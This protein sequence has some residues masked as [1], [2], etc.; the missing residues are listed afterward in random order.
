[1]I[2]ILAFLYSATL[3]TTLSGMEIV[4]AVAV[5]FWIFDSWKK[6]RLELP[7]WRPIVL[8]SGIVALG[9]LIGGATF[10][11]KLSDLFRLRFF[12]FFGAS[13]HL[14]KAVHFGKNRRWR[15]AWLVVFFI[16][17]VYSTLQH[18]IPLDLVRP[19]GHKVIL[20]ADGAGNGPLVL[21]LFNHH[22]TF[23]NVFLLYGPIFLSYGFC[24]FPRFIFAWGWAVWIYVLVLWTDSRIAW[25]AIPFTVVAVG[26]GKSWRWRGPVVMFLASLGLLLTLYTSNPHVRERF[27]KTFDLSHAQLSMTPRLKLW[28]AQWEFF[29]ESPLIGVGWN[30]NERRGHSMMESL[31]PGAINYSGHGHSLPLQMLAT[32]GIAGCVAFA[33]IWFGI[34]RMLGKCLM[35]A[36]ANCEERWIALGLSA[37]FIGF[38]I[39]GLTQWNFGDAEVLHNLMF[40]WGAASALV[41]ALVALVPGT[42]Q[43]RVNL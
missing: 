5:G 25:V 17:C 19:E 22:L 16:V 7:L 3:I 12:L 35:A 24:A 23:S 33:W 8:F 28:R 1:M 34:A 6:Q 36:H 31:Y 43:D 9:I 15:A 39:Q 41:P 21:G 29:K 14:F 40:L 27:G 2:G 37:S 30:N 38:W 20:F 13:A 32:T 18:F 26:I 4:S 10:E 42:I 11:E